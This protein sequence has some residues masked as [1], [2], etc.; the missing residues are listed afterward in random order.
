MKKKISFVRIGIL[1]SLLFLG[2]QST[3]LAQAAEDPG[4]SMYMYFKVAPENQAEFVKRETTLWAEVARKA[5]AQGNLVF[6]AFLE[7]EGGYDLQNS[8]NYLIVNTYKNIDAIGDVWS[9]KN[10]AAGAPNVSMDKM[11]TRG[12]STIT[13]TFFLHDEGWTQSATAVPDKDFKFISMVYHKSPDP[14]AFIALENKVWAPFIKGAMD[15]KQVTQGGWGNAI[16]LSPTG[17]NIPFN[18]VSYDLYPSFKEA[19]NPTWDPKI[20]IPDGMADIGKAETS[21]GG[22]V[23]RVV[24]VVSPDQK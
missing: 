17:P 18:S 13:S 16:V 11:N 12:M 21:R 20:V 6:W 8:S 10:I 4:I 24:K 19:L 15:K 22:I 3:T 23:Y 9:E 5:M 2:T 14:S 1:L 7:K